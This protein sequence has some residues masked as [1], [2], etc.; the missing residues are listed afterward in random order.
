VRNAAR[1]FEWRLPRIRFRSPRDGAI[2]Q[3]EDGHLSHQILVSAVEQSP[4]PNRQTQN[5]DGRSS[6]P[7]PPSAPFVRFGESLEPFI[8][9]GER[10]LIR[11]NFLENIS[12][13]T[14]DTLGVGEILEQ[15]TA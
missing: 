1:Y 6:K 2:P 14:A 13:W 5:D 11:S 10:H 8:R 7:S 12:P 4:A 9:F 3:I 15:A